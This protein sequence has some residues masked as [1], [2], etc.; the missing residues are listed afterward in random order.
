M[1]GCSGRFICLSQTPLVFP[2]YAGMFPLDSKNLNAQLG[3]PR[4]CGDVPADMQSVLA[5]CRFSPRMRGCS[6]G[7][8]V[9]VGYMPVFPAYAGMFPVFLGRI[10]EG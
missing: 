3:F 5:T 9:G 8:A 1:R 10:F 4:V 2:A 6:G 7:H